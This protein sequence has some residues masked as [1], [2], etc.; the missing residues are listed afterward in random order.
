MTE[1]S[2]SELRAWAGRLGD[3]DEATRIESQAMLLAHAEVALP[4]VLQVFASGSPDTRREV[5]WFLAHALLEGDDVRSVL[6]RAARDASL[7][8][9]ELALAAQERLDSP[10]DWEADLAAQFA[11]LQELGE[12]GL[13][14]DA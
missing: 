7:D 14:D 9:R 1:P 10:E 12:D 3:P 5:V 11:F 13:P 6:E 2:V 4:H 8:V